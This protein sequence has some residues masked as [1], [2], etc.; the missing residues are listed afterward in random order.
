MHSN[1]Q[2]WYSILLW[3]PTDLRLSPLDSPFSFMSECCILFVHQCSL[4]LL[5]SNINTNTLNAFFSKVHFSVFPTLNTHILAKFEPTDLGLVS[6]ELSYFFSSRITETTI[7]DFFTL[8]YLFSRH[9]TYNTINW[10]SPIQLC[11]MPW[12][13]NVIRKFG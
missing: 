7:F 5:P 13:Q 8:G 11:R 12:L 6:F 3:T 4:M 10:A 2:G 9:V 1:G